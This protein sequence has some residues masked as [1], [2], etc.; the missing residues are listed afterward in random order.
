SVVFLAL[1]AITLAISSEVAARDMAEKSHSEENVGRTRLDDVKYYGNSGN[2]EG[3][4]LGRGGYNGPQRGHYYC[5]YGCCRHCSFHSYACCR[6]CSA[7]G[8]AAEAEIED[9]P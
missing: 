1:L 2:P 5:R 7:P 4:S 6:C 3:E 9:K 8:K